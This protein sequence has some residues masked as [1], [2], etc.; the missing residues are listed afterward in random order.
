MDVLARAEDL[1]ELTFDVWKRRIRQG[2]RGISGGS[3]TECMTCKRLMG[4][5][6]LLEASR[7]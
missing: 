7:S 5:A 2:D 1:E 4:P 3:P 6:S